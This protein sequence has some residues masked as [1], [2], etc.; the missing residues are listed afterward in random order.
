MRLLLFGVTG[1]T[2]AQLLTQ[3]LAAGHQV[4]AVAR[5]PARVRTTNSAE[6]PDQDPS[7]A[8][9]QA[10]RLTVL[11]GD[12]LA[13]D[14]WRR[15]VPGHDAVLSCLGSTDRKHP[16]TVYSQG[17][18]NIVEAMHASGVDRLLCLS[19]A[20][21]EITPDVPLPQRLV[22]RYV[23]QRLYRHGYADMARMENFMASAAAG[24]TAWTVVRP[25]MLTDGP[26]TGHYRTAANGHLDRPKSLSRADLA[27]CL[28]ARVEDPRTHRAVL[29]VAY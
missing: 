29:E 19:S 15:A 16:T 23:I 27:H 11:R 28:L 13:P 24:D 14:T 3:A 5:D 12:A 25:P 20:G 18:R 8:Q 2:G 1:G 9:A 10:S 7:Q 4:T 6:D 17:T 22:T 26:L 21:L